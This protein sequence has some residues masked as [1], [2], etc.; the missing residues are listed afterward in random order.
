MPKGAKRRK[1]ARKKQQEQTNNNS[2]ATLSH[3]DDDLQVH[4]EKESDGGDTGSP[5][6]Q[7]NHNH[8]HEG[9]EME[10]EKREDTLSVR[11][12]IAENEP[13]IGLN[14]NGEDTQK[15]EME[16][17]GNSAVQIMDWELEPEDESERKNG[18]VEFVESLKESNGGHK[19]QDGGT[20][21][22]SSSSSSDDESNV[23]EKNIV[24]IESG[25]SKEEAP[26]FVEERT[27]FADLIK[28]TDLPQ[29]TQVTDDVP[30][31]DVYDL[32]VDEAYDPIASKEETATSADPVKTTDLPEVTQATDGVLVTDA[33][34]LSVEEPTEE[35]YDPVTKNAF[36]VNLVDTA[37]FPE[38]TQVAD[39]LPD[40]EAYSLVVEEPSNLIVETV[41]PVDSETVSK[42]VVQVNDSTPHSTD[43]EFEL[44]K[45][46]N[47][48]GSLVSQVVMDTGSQLVND[49]TA[50]ENHACYDF[51]YVLKENGEN[52]SS[53]LSQV[54]M[55]TGSQ[56][57]EDKVSPTTVEYSGVTR[58][59]DSISDIEA[60][61]LVAE[62]PSNLL[63][64]TIPPISLE[65]VSEEVVHPND[66][67]PVE[68]PECSGDF[69][70]GLKENGENEGSG[71]SQVVMDTGSQLVNDS[72]LMENPAC[73]CG[74][75]SGLIENG[76][77]GTSGGSPVLPDAESQPK[78]D[79]V[80]PSTVKYIVAS[81]VAIGSAVKEDKE[82][83]MLSSSV[84]PLENS[85]GAE[86][87]KDQMTTEC[88]DSRP[89]VAS[90]PQ[91]VH[92]TSW[93]SCC[94]VFELFRASN[95]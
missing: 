12:I 68:N 52:E 34:N 56:P 89:L 65:N 74:L 46:G 48:D 29:V 79:V 38:V 9:E 16:M 90:A 69:E 33:Y 30:T 82:R 45:N 57:E 73:S 92:K 47:D 91:P 61:S 28:T 21:S 80:S 15:R 72:T 81:S 77:I 41:P 58:V 44:K 36:P 85:N 62:E 1:A 93:I 49:S 17:E 10:M 76:K 20:S 59:T 27:T 40:I 11:L 50:I 18:C 13:L 2:S 83:L 6:S 75:E 64:K 19:S 94:G 51:G 14:G 31:M 55:D 42:D 7:D 22:S 4:Y 88:S 35:A 70:S 37:D 5:T 53:G 63:M 54:V 67:T 8:Q 66:S 43:S 24:V 25:E 23:V 87:D 32:A 86:N 84:P 60:C 95:A 78:E 71:V 26:C 39:G 3:G